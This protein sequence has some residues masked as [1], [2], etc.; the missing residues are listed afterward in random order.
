MKFKIKGWTETLV[1][2]VLGIFLAYLFN[3]TLGFAL[4]TDLPVVAV[5]STSM[6]HDETTPVVHYQWLE[7]NLGVTRE[8][9]DSWPISDGFD[10]GD[11]LLVVGVP[12]EDLKIGDVIVFRASKQSYPI[13]HRIV[14]INEDGTFVTKGDHNPTTDPWKI[15]YNEISGKVIFILPKLGYFKLITTEIWFS[16]VGGLGGI[17]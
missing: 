14:K 4:S 17:L 8:Q 11:I 1:Y 10:R 2:I 9:I 7:K 15:S 5:V 16:I 13:V 6:L 12:R 3:V